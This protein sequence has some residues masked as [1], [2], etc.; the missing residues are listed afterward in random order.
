MRNVARLIAAGTT[1]LLLV[2]LA[3]ATSAHAAVSSSSPAANAKLTSM[4]AT[5]SVTFDTPVLS[6]SLSVAPPAGSTG[7][8]CPTNTFTPPAATISCTPTMT[9]SGAFPDGTYTVTYSSTLPTNSGSYVFYFDAHTPVVSNLVINDNPYNKA[10]KDAGHSIVVSGTT[11]PGANVDVTLAST[12]LNNPA[13]QTVLADG[14]SGSFSALF[15]PTIG[16]GDLTATATP[17]D[18]VNTGV[19]VQ[20]F[21]VKDIV[22]PT[23]LSSSPDNNAAEQP[24][25]GGVPNGITFFAS[26]PLAQSTTITLAKN[27]QPVLSTKSVTGA[28]VTATPVDVLP[29]GTYTATAT[30]VDLANNPSASVT[31]T[32]VID[33]QVPTA[34]TVSAAPINTARKTTYTVTGTGEAG[35]TINLTMSD[36]GSA[37]VVTAHPTV[38]NAGT[39]TTTNDVSSLNDGAVQISATQQDQ[40]GNVSSAWTGGTT[41]DT[42]SPRISTSPPAAFDKSSYPAGAPIVA[43]VS[44]KVDNGTTTAGELG[45][46]VD[47]LVSDGAGGHASDRVTTDANGL[48]TAHV[49][50]TSLADGPLT[51]SIV[52]SDGVG[53]PSV[54]GSAGATK[55][56]ASPAAPTVTMTS[57]INDGNKSSITVSGTAEPLSTVLIS[58][59]DSNDP[60]NTTAPVQGSVA[61]SA[62]G[63][64]AL[65]GIDVH[66]LKDGTLTATVVAVDGAGNTGAVGTGTATKDTVAP[67][68][69]TLTVPAYANATTVGAVPLSGTAEPL[70]TIVLHITDS[71]AQSITPDPTVPVAA[72]GTWSTSLDFSD[73]AEDAIS[74][75]AVA[76]DAAGNVGDGPTKPVVKDTGVPGTPSS[77][78]APTAYTYA[79]RTSDLLVN[80]AVAPADNGDSGLSAVITIADGP[81]TAPLVETVPVTSNQFS[82]T[83]A[84]SRIQFLPDGQLSVRVQIV[85]AAGNT[86]ISDITALPKDVTK[87]AIASK[88][89]AAG[90]SLQSVGSVVVAFNEALVAN[91]DPN[92]APYSS[93]TLKKGGVSLAGSL[94]F[95]SDHKTLTFTPGAPLT[96]GTYDVFVHATDVNDNADVIDDDAGPTPTFSFS[97][98][99]TAPV[100]PTV[101]SVTDPVNSVNKTAVA[102][103]GNAT[104]QGL[105]V[106]VTITGTSGSVS[107]SAT[108]GAGGAYTVSGIDVSSLPDGTL[109]AVAA[110]TDAAGNAG[111]SGGT[112]TATKETVLP[113]VSGLAATASHY[114][115]FTTTVTGTLSEAGT[116]ALS[117]TDG[118]H[119]ASG[120]GTVAGNNTFTGTLDLSGFTTGSVTVT[121]RATDTAGNPGPVASTT[122]THDA[123][124]PP[125]KPAAP[126]ATAGDRKASVAFTAPASTG[127]APITSYTVV[128]SGGQT[129]TGTS[130]PIIVTGL[131]DAVAYT[132][133]VKATNRAGSGVASDASNAVTPMGLSSVALSPLPARIVYGSYLTLSGTV[134]RTDG[135]AAFGTVKLY[136]RTD[137]GVVRLLVTRAV[138]STGAWVYR[139]RPSTN[140]TYYAVY[141]GDSVNKASAASTRRKV[142]VAVRVTAS[143]P[144][145]SHL[146]NQVVTGAV[147]PNKAGT[148]AY[149]YRI[150]STGSLVKLA[151]VRLSSTSTYR[152]SVRLPA[153]KTKLRV[154]VPTTP[155]NYAGS[156]NFTATRT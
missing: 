125:G 78:L 23:L 86:S 16:D 89:P 70:S 77:A 156:V 30:L 50:I 46:V 155:N 90:A 42:V 69:P 22:V 48:F 82:Y 126:V 56:T 6:A 106:T 33:S 94:A 58:I 9:P 118:T 36:S 153:G 21:G 137:A 62:G 122:T 41:K 131:K 142:Y 34:P 20:A 47:V 109:T 28:T 40:A 64:Y 3:P 136:T 117:A 53:N 102:V 114:S 149:L 146:V 27:G 95:S 133:T 97:V 63:T 79:N 107:K 31:R 147:S 49:T 26:E 96:E 18:E 38:S 124:V 130:S 139:F 119:T 152:F 101:S 87:L 104:E 120:S 143:A 151:T 85:D 44:G 7:F 4:A 17:R 57:P 1:S 92:A 8:T 144:T 25:T 83:F 111:P 2:G 67:L 115:A 61:A 93:I 5:V 84:N 129:A 45:D 128:S 88:T 123:A 140:L 59:N 148:T 55:D 132:F 14:T 113:T 65:G 12:G 66:L 75:T 54:A 13:L 29:D 73:L 43:A 19:A 116:V 68:A 141:G 145:G 134:H 60:N 110:S 76:R 121:A 35:A 81:G 11:E 24:S 150:T 138:T 103:S 71:A 108:S 100:A 135:S 80:G 51:A 32:F 154:L 99:V 39:W 91:T 37:H 10:S 112:K 15:A 74:V 105:T 98:D 72:N 52:A 127:G